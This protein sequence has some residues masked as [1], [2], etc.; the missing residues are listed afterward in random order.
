MGFTPYFLCHLHILCVNKLLSSKCTFYIRH[1]FF[2][3]FFFFIRKFWKYKWLDGYFEGSLII[4]TNS[5]QV[6]NQSF[7]IIDIRKIEFKFV[8]YYGKK[9]DF[10]HNV[11][12]IL[13]QGTSNLIKLSLNNGQTIKAFFKLN[14]K[15]HHKF[16][17]PFIVQMIKAEKISFLRGIELLDINDYDDIQQFKRKH[18]QKEN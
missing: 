17:N 15:E 4:N 7:E 13:S 9:E 14:F 18:L 8:N 2:S 12:P 11:N 1:S 3:I 10:R 5:I 16:L 6:A